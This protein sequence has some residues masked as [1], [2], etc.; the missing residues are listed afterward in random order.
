MLCHYVRTPAGQRRHHQTPLG[1]YLD[2][3]AAE[4]EGQGF[5]FATVQSDVKTATAFGEYLIAQGR[6]LS[7]LRDEDIGTFVLWYRSMP[8]RPGPR[9]V[10]PEGS[11]ALMES[12][13]GTVRKLLRHLRSIGAVP[14]EET[15]AREVPCAEVL[16]DYLLF[17]EI[18]RGF[19]GSTVRM[20]SQ[21]CEALLR[22]LGERRPGFRMEDLTS[23]AV[24]D[25]T[26]EVLALGSGPR[27]AQMI[28]LSVEAFIQHLRATGAVAATCRP[29]LPRRRRYQLAA[30]PA[31]L[32][33]KQIERA[34]ASIDRTSALG[35]RDYAIFATC[36]TYGLR[37]SEVVGLR[38]DDIDWRGGVL[39][40][41]Q[42]KTRR[43][44]RLPL[45][46]PII[47]ALVAYLRDRRATDD[48]HVFQKIHAPLGPMTRAATYGVVRKALIGAGIKAA[49]Y[50]PHLLRHTRATSLVR[51]GKPLKVVGDL[52]GHRVP[53]ATLIYCKLAVEDLRGVALELPEA[54]R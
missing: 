28:S 4:L 21:V 14:V 2:G 16:K 36:A 27:R 23:E 43:E 30:L 18:H 1:P 35:R 13:V 32:E 44:L 42:F 5:A 15:R 3:F 17:L 45:V 31:A 48:R 51:Q 19:A 10:T 11:H 12:L 37:T 40:V 6:A 7:D 38:L 26:V 29:F 24:E 20:H 41:R 53:E 9:R 47:D 8:R 25:A 52:L 34:L 54:S 49:Q 22:K 46:L 33:W 39:R 50:G